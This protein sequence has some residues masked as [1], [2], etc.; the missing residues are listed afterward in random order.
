MLSA[1]SKSSMR[2]ATLMPRESPSAIWRAGF[3][4]R[5]KADHGNDGNSQQHLGGYETRRPAAGAGGTIPVKPT[6]RPQQVDSAQAKERRHQRELGQQ[7]PAVI[8]LRQARQLDDLNP[9]GKHTG[10]D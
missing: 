8:S 1:T 9:G 3:E 4:A 2:V 5:E 6:P 10:D 7:R